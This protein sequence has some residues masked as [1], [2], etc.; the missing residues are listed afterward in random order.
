[1]GR[2]TWLEKTP[3][4]ASLCEGLP[5]D[6]R[7]IGFLANYDIV[8]CGDV[9]DQEEIEVNSADQE[10]RGFKAHNNK[11]QVLGL[12]AGAQGKINTAEALKKIDEIEKQ[13]QEFI[14]SEEGRELAEIGLAVGQGEEG[15]QGWAYN[16]DRWDEKEEERKNIEWTNSAKEAEKLKELKARGMGPGWERLS[17]AGNKELE[18]ELDEVYEARPSFNGLF[19]QPANPPPPP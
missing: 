9:I 6:Q 4:C 15:P 2:L 10:L 16:R 5:R 18:P 13:R 17:A 11:R 1:M 14:K 19:G 3:L 8:K 7:V 12:V